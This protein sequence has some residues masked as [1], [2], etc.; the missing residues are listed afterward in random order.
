MSRVHPGFGVSGFRFSGVG[1][2]V[3]GG[4]FWLSGFGP[5]SGGCMDSPITFLPGC[6]IFPPKML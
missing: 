2:R 3:Y 5:A 6:V 4:R 1:F